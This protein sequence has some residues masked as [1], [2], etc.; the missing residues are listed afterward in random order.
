[1]Q[2]IKI[3]I[4]ANEKE[5]VKDEKEISNFIRDLNDK[6]ENN[7]IYFQLIADDDINYFNSQEIEQSDLFFIL[8]YHE[9]QENTIRKFHLAYD[10]FMK[11]KN[12]K[13]STY[14]KK[15]TQSITQTVLD[16][17]NELDSELGH[18]YNVY[19]NVDSIKLNLV[20]R[21]NSLGFHFGKLDVKDGT[22]Y[23][24]QKELM[25]LEYIPI[26]AN[27]K[28]L[29]Q[30]KQE[31]QEL[32]EKY[33]DL[34]EK[35]RLN[36]N[37]ES[38][39]IELEVIEK[40]RDQ[41]KE[42]IHVL[43]KNIL[44]LQSTFV[45]ISN[46][47]NLSKR[48]IYA[49]KCLEEGDIKSAKEALKLS[50]IKEEAV[51]L[52][53]LQEIT[54]AEIQ[55]KVNELIQRVHTLILDVQNVKRFHEIDIT[56]KEAIHIEKEAG[57]Y[58]KSLLLYADDLLERHEYEN[59]IKF[60]NQFLDYVKTE[61]EKT[62][63]DD[64]YQAYIILG[65]ANSMLEQFS[66]AE[67]QFSIAM[68]L[69]EEQNDIEHVV[70]I[71]QT[72]I[73]YIYEKTKEIEKAEYYY[74]KMIDILKN[75]HGDKLEL[76]NIEDKL[77]ALYVNHEM[78]HKA[79]SY[80]EE[81]NQIYQAELETNPNHK[82]KHK[83]F[84]NYHNLLS[85][86][87]N[88]KQYLKFADN[89]GKTEQLIQELEAEQPRL[90]FYKKEYHQSCIVYYLSKLSIKG[91]LPGKASKA[92]FK[93]ADIFHETYDVYYYLGAACFYQ[94]STLYDDGNIKKYRLFLKRGQR[95]LKLLESSIQKIEDPAI[96]SQKLV[97]CLM[98]YLNLADLYKKVGLDQKA[99][100]YYRNAFELYYEIDDETM[101]NRY[102]LYC[103]HWNMID[104]L[105]KQ[106]RYQEA[107]NMYQLEIDNLKF[108]IK[109]E[110]DNYLVEIATSYNN[111][112]VLH[113]QMG[114]IEEAEQDFQEKIKYCKKFPD[115]SILKEDFF[116]ITYNNL[117]TIY[118]DHKRYK[119]S[120]SYYEKAAKYQEHLLLDNS[121]KYEKKLSETYR[122]IGKNNWALKQ[123]QKAVPYLEKAITI[124]EKM[125][126]NDDI[127]LEK[128]HL[129]N[130]YLTIASCYYRLKKYK[131]AIPCYQKA[132]SLITQLA[133]GDYQL[134]K[135]YELDYA[136]YNLGITYEMIHQYS[137]MKPC[138]LNAKEIRI[139][140]QYQSRKK[141]LE[142]LESVYRKLA[143]ACSNLKEKEEANS[144]LD[145]ANTFLEELQKL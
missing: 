25:S 138:L 108:M 63:D 52:L 99:E 41:V 15:S 95:S 42:Q 82:I 92:F 54:K 64:I 77:G 126:K 55:I 91:L 85:V 65:K 66:K 129:H 87:L 104:L 48:Q 45:Q 111:L 112:G 84:L 37:V 28:E 19:E 118:Y 17:M 2:K 124:K 9:I 10:N 90:Y 6:Y 139:H 98:L 8:F 71:C 143:T 134:S 14:F 116:E 47:G 109:E 50:E 125:K 24:S 27:N 114:K 33:W 29:N 93:L 32:E 40:R 127:S 142:E 107:E 130:A 58:R 30:L 136:Y 34:K 86:Y 18:Y 103:I 4:L 61:E 13:I 67:N 101:Y 137:K 135:S 94:A 102:I 100:Q 16:F 120:L 22:L 36:A 119:E 72:I 128:L 78:F 123:Y 62:T 5:L 115:D 132:I 51:K 89:I 1:M 44:E 110:P 26:V 21:L 122:Y 7:D 53:K 70:E 131:Q 39:S 83:L 133:D 81:A 96:R 69:A 56:Y 3:Y 31:A 106:K 35:K 23:A 49:Q 113:N 38:V 145:Q 140:A 141:Q 73:T 11:C 88:Q 80:L 46:D 97:Y 144:Y 75:N 43:E 74:R 59:C 121:E 76:A 105:T 117:A 20:L 68:K 79:G 60:A 12:P 57:L